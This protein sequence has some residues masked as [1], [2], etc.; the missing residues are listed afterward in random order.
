MEVMF[1]SRKEAHAP[2]DAMVRNS[3][4]RLSSQSGRF[5]PNLRRHLQPIKL[6][7]DDE[8][9][10]LTRTLWCWAELLKKYDPP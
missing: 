8:K 6:E 3:E 10:F 1:W 2:V 5:S 7:E 4:N 9:V